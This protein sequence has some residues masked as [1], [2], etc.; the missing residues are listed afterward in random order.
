MEAKQHAVS[1]LKDVDDFEEIADE[2]DACLATMGGS[3]PFLSSAWLISWLRTVGVNF[4]LRVVALRRDGQLVAGAPLVR[5]SKPYY[6]IPVREL[7]WIGDHTSDRLQFVVRHDDL[8]E[9]ALLWSAVLEHNPDVD[10]I[11]LEE[12]PASS[13]TEKVIFAQGGRIG[14]E[15][16]SVLPYVDVSNFPHYESMLRKK[17]RTEMR[18]RPKVFDTWGTWSFDVMTGAAISGHVDEMKALEIASHKGTGG[19]AFFGYDENDRFLRTAVARDNSTFQPVVFTLRVD[20]TLVAYLLVLRHGNALNAYN[21]A[22]EPGREK[23]SPGKWLCHQA[24]HWAHEQGL[25]EFD[26]LRGAT[27]MKSRWQP[28][29]RPSGRV[30]LFRR[31]VLGSL[32]RFA[33]FDLRPRLKAR[34]VRG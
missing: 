4:E 24:M 20:G 19:Y 13:P 10:I 28:V 16:S 21:I 32:L 8:D 18:T 14:H 34:K 17:F 1:V 3:N 15:I 25:T 26:F 29:D 9:A 7:S 5:R 27:A 2:W 12:V 23:G 33:V 31:R 6:R 22:F 30:I 11:R